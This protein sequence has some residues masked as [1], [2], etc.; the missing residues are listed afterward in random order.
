MNWTQ[1]TVDAINAR[2]KQNRKAVKE[3][4][5]LLKQKAAKAKPTQAMPTVKP[6]IFIGIDPGANTGMAVWHRTS[7]KFTTVQTTTIFKALK[8]VEGFI[9]DNHANGGIMLVFEDARKRKVFDKNADGS[10]DKSKLQGAG[11]VK[12]DC[13]IWQEAC[14]YWSLNYSGFYWRNPAPNGKTNKMAKDKE[15]SSAMLGIEG[16]SSE[17]ARCAAFLVWKI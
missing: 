14:E 3:R 4:S 7:G 1:E 8:I 6:V 5:G 15:T 11:S 17:H 2:I 13:S 9:H 10:F 12:R 16:N